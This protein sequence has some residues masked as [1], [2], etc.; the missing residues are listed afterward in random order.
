[1]EHANK[2]YFTKA[3]TDW[4][5]VV[6]ENTHISPSHYDN[7][8]VK[9]GLRNSDGTGVLAGLTNVSQVH[10]YIMYEDEK[11]PDD[12]KL[13]YRG[14]NVSDID[15]CKKMMLEQGCIYSGPKS[16]CQLQ[17][18]EAEWKLLRENPCPSIE[19]TL[20]FHDKFGQENKNVLK[21]LTQKLKAIFKQ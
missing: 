10:G 7:Y 21:Q 20:F 3:L 8:K 6:E 15:V 14:I 13:S 9:R 18:P 1:M 4:C 11:I 5:G 12:G 2:E 16:L 19:F 17:F